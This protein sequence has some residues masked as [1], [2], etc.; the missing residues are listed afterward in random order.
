MGTPKGKGNL[1]K[2]LNQAKERPEKN[3]SLILKASDTGIVS[4]EDL[5][6]IRAKIGEDAY[7]QEMECNFNVARAG[8]IYSKEIN[9][10]RDDGRVLDFGNDGSQLTHT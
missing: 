6:E 2:A 1:Y 10:A 9:A 8:A 4:E 5:G 7:Q 3:Y